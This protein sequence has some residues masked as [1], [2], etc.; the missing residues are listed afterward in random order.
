MYLF[1][2]VIIE[3]HYIIVLKLIYLIKDVKSMVFMVVDVT[4]YVQTTVKTI[5][6]IFRAEAVF[7]VRPGGQG[8]LA[9]QVRW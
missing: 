3:H 1:K 6:V 2:V 5:F 7:L 8:P 4:N 9:I